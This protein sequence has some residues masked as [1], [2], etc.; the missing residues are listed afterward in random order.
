MKEALNYVML[1]N[2][3]AIRSMSNLHSAIFYSQLPVVSPKEQADCCLMEMQLYSVTW[4]VCV[5]FD[6]LHQ[7]V[8]LRIPEQFWILLK[9]KRCD[10]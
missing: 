8:S 3:V 6:R 4:A 10:L 2:N 7:A 9:E 5:T 1:N